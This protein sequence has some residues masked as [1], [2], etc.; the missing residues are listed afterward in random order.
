MSK[1]SKKIALSKFSLTHLLVF[2]SFCGILCAVSM[3]SFQKGKEVEREAAEAK[4]AARIAQDRA[5]ELEAA[6]QRLAQ[7]QLLLDQLNEQKYGLI[8]DVLMIKGQRVKSSYHANGMGATDSA[9]IY[10]VTDN[11]KMGREGRD[12]I[13]IRVA[14]IED[15]SY[16]TPEGAASQKFLDDMIRGKSIKVYV[17]GR[18]KNGNR[19]AYIVVDEVNV[20]E[21]MVEKGISK[22]EKTSSFVDG[23]SN[24]KES[25]KSKLNELRKKYKI[26]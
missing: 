11:K 19:L 17:I 24:L 21:L 5:A 3:Y 6:T 4:M 12:R 22:P 18:A 14:G 8:D 23:N 13:K 10:V 7:Q 20:S 1:E 2:V 26:R 16:K 15:P 9:N 25:V